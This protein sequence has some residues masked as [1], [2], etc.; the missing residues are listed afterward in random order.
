MKVYTVLRPMNMK[1]HAEEYFNSVVNL[2]SK[3]GYHVRHNGMSGKE[4]S[5]LQVNNN[6]CYL[7]SDEYMGI[8]NKLPKPKEEVIEWATDIAKEYYKNFNS[9]SDLDKHRVLRNIYLLKGYNTAETEFLLYAPLDLSKQK[10]H[11]PEYIDFIFPL[12]L[13]DIFGIPTI[14]LNQ[15]KFSGVPNHD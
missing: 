13:A 12:K 4:S 11:T 14:S 5:L 8:T 7:P 10:H 6:L 15:F 9:L 3:Q 1:T 2:L